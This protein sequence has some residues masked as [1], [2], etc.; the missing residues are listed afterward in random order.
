M[1]GVW[2]RR[3]TLGGLAALPA[4]RFPRAQRASSASP[5]PGSAPPALPVDK[6]LETAFDQARRVEVPV[7]LD[8][9]GPYYFVIDTGSNRTV[10]SEEVA[11]TLN[12]PPDGTVSVHGILSAELAPV[13][14]VKRIRVSDVVSSN[15]Q[16]PVEPASKLGADGLLGIDMLKG[17]SVAIRFRD[18]TFHIAGSGGISMGQ[19]T[20]SRIHS[21]SAPFTV[22]ARYRS[23][24]LL[25]VDAFAAG[26][27]ITAFLDSGSQV[28]V[29]NLALRQAA[30]A[31]DH[32]LESRLIHSVLISATG[33][34]ATAEF[35]PLPDLRIGGRDVEAPL[36]AYADLHVF[37]LWDLRDTPALLM[38]VDTL[39][40]F[41][42]VAF[43][44]GEKLITFWPSRTPIH[45]PP[46]PAPR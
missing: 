22:P 19:Q 2:T 8:G 20:T 28:T 30:L 41:D 11:K 18:Q 6:V 7:T 38:G 40:R 36:V 29:A 9:R 33:Q 37:D 35:G 45:P 4:L 26:K 13:V 39:R 3:G 27:P 5:P 17:R 25:I 1:V 15:L 34:R 10:V 44:F 21:P 23:G 12:L 46:P 16:A 31:V 43:D 32:T 14:L 24:Q 42:E